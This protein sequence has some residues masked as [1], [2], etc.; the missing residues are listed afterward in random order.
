V[1]QGPSRSFAL[2]QL[3]S[4]EIKKECE[5]HIARHF[6]YLQRLQEYADRKT[7]REGLQ[8]QKLI[9][10]RKWW[11]LAPG[12]NPFK[13]RSKKNLEI[14]SFTLAK[15]IRERTYAP[16]P[17]VRY[18]RIKEDGTQR[19][20]NIFQLPDSAVSR[21]AYE[22]LL[23]KNVAKFSA[24][25]Y[26]YRKDK[27]AH[28]AA[29]DIFS[30]WRMLDRIYVAEYDFSKFFDRIDH[31]YLL[32][33]IHEHQFIVSREEEQLIKAFLES[34]SAEMH[35]YPNGLEK[36]ERGIPQG[37]SISLF[38]ANI[39]C[40]EL[41][42]ELERL[43]VGFA[44]YADDT[45]VWSE[46]YTKVVRAYY[47]IDE[48]ARRMGVPINL[49]K[50]HG[51]NLISR[52]ELSGEITTKD[53]IDYLGYRISLDRISIKESR[54]RK[55]KAKIS[56]LIFQNLL[57]PLKK[58]IFNSGR[59]T[60]ELDLDYVTA[61]RQVRAYMYG[62]LTN[63]KL[64]RYLAGR[65]SDLNFRGLMS[66]Y[67]IVNDS[68]QLALLDGWLGHTFRQAL[69][70]RERMWKQKGR[71]ALPGPVPDWIDEV[72]KIKTGKLP[73]GDTEDISVPSFLLI[74]RA[75]QMAIAKSGL[76]AVANPASQYYES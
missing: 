24:Y 2:R 19:P 27:T 67:P 15:K 49:I 20:L 47:V 63:E 54:V 43:G 65:T 55:I 52:R 23:L 5:K 59:L 45:V 50:S 34:E 38:L 1:T 58:G 66:Y 48:N 61:I 40:W 3:I 72:T 18:Y 29:M 75:L 22:S 51:I 12:F 46:D 41:D 57:Q 39:A 64:H 37:T 10:L 69:R 7:R 13:V 44:R 42:R 36:R 68:A 53:S 6:E 31:K 11:K 14:Y 70:A 16:K 28:H 25:S 17:C 76:L 30:E 71:Q 32:D 62:G 60:S 33:V 73:G 21:L 8:F 35:E 9:H 26:A 4:A 74:N 56:Y